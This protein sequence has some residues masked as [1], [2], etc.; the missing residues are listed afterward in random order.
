MS[1]PE[2]KNTSVDQAP[3]SV[4]VVIPT[5]NSENTIEECLKSVFKQSYL[6]QEVIIVDDGSRDSTLEKLMEC[7]NICPPEVQFTLIKQENSGPSVARNRGVDNAKSAWIAFLDSDDLWI[8]DKLKIESHFIKNFPNTKLLGGTQKD[9]PIKVSFGDLLYKNFFQTSSVFVSK[10]CMLKYPFNEAQKFSEDYRC[11]LNI[12][13]DY[14]AYLIPPLRAFPYDQRSMAFFSGGLSSKMTKMLRGEL[15]NYKDLY[16]DGKIGS[17]T[18]LKT[19]TY[20]I[21]K[22]VRRKVL[23]KLET[24][25]SLFKHIFKSKR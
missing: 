6:P 3:I 16:R 23:R 22:F 14:D 20:S 12:V 8:S 13:Y 11:W 15:S 4:A 7:K 17:A 5:F 19:Y 24:F 9:K 10:E 18:L 21:V 2:I 25:K 1:M